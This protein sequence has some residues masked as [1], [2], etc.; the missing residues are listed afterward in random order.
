MSRAQQL[1][2]ITRWEFRRWFK[3][4]DQ[5]V[6]L[7][8]SVA[9]GLAIWGGKS[10]LDRATQGPINVHVLNPEVLE[11]TPPAEGRV[12]LVGSPAAGEAELGAALGSG[13]IDG[14][15]RLD[16]IERAR[17][18]VL[19]E[20]VW[21]GELESALT[22]ARRRA[23]LQ[24]VELNEEQLADMSAPFEI[25]VAY[26]EG[27]AEPSS[28]GDRVA[29]GILIGLMILGVMVGLSYQ[30]I[31]ITSEKQLRVTESIVSAVSAQTWIDGKILGISLLACVSTLTYVVS[32]LLFT[33][34][35]GFFGPGLS[36]LVKTHPV[37]LLAIVALALCGFLF[38]HT[39]FAAI[40]ATI[41]DPNTSA[42]SAMLM[43][44]LLP[45]GVAFWALASPDALIIRLL[46]L[47]PLTAP[48][49][50]AARLL[51][52]EV[53]AW[54]V[55]LAL[56]LLVASIWLLRRIAGKVFGLAML[57]YGKEPGWRE[58]ARWVKAA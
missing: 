38:W 19:K 41:N 12:R 21:I 18:E 33:F 15:L 49:V 29:A 36:A 27:A 52:T 48:S 25:D 6:T 37:P 46:G 56:A 55:L 57:M 23:K 16:S 14:I 11:F 39:F 24:L 13:E 31:A 3:I 45:L 43:L 42:R 47:L 35:A 30:F 51:L 1:F 32:I 2:E 40:A 26:Q 50:L 28:F 54:E 34:L 8:L 9:I 5:V 4:K 7:V 17:L 22:A 53:H 58:M 20:P 10:L 44:P